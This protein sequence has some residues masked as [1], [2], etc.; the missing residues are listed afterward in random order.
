MD[1]EASLEHSR[2]FDLKGKAMGDQQVLWNTAEASK[3]AEVNHRY[4]GSQ[5]HTTRHQQMAT[6][7][8]SNHQQEAG[9]NPAFSA[10]GTFATLA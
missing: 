5:P 7:T 6:T 4:G 9:G 8:G 1:Y 2:Q 3:I 10:G